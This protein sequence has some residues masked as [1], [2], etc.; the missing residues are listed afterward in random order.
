MLSLGL[1]LNQPQLETVVTLPDCVVSLFVSWSIAPPS[2]SNLRAQ[3]KVE[4][5]GGGGQSPPLPCRSPLASTEQ[6]FLLLQ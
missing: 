2:S 5:L 3:L 4:F 1:Q 6:D